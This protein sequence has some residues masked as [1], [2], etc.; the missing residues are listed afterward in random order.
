VTP[1]F[2]PVPVPV[3]VN[4][5]PLAGIRPPELVTAPTTL[6]VTVPLEVKVADPTAVTE[7]MPTG[8]IRGGV[9]VTPLKPAANVTETVICVVFPANTVRLGGTLSVKP[10]KLPDAVP[11]AGCELKVPLS[12]LRL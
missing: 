1:E 8:I 12:P 9:T 10:D 7:A 11:L 4:C 5:W 3:K 2:V 6:K